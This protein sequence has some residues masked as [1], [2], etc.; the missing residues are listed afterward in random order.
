[1]E[2]EGKNALEVEKEEASQ[3]EASAQKTKDR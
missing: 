3:K 1:V 2:K